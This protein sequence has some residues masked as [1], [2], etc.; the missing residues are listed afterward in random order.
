MY[1]KMVMV[2]GKWVIKKRPLTARERRHLERWVA[3]FKRR[4]YEANS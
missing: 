4:R 3:A 2:R 1:K